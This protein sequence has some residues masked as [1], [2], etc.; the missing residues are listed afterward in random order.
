MNFEQT[1]DILTAISLVLAVIGGLFALYQWRNNIKLKHAEYIDNLTQKI[2]YDTDII[3][4]MYILEYN[5]RWYS[6]NFHGSEYEPIF[7][8]A[9]FNFSYICYLR[10]RKI[11]TDNE[12]KF[13]EYK[14][15]KILTD[16]NIQNYFYNL[17]HY[18]KSINQPIS[19]LYLFKYGE[20]QSLFDENFYNPNAHLNCKKYDKFLYF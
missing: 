5:E 4:V 7:D 3:K 16:Y 17:Y 19:F 6:Y 20:E 13:F 1:S 12:F 11:I 18:C 2:Y 14:I 9:L 15:Y 8:K 10:K